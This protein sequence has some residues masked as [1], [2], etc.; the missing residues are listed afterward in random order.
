M[1]PTLA[2]KLKKQQEKTRTGESA[3]ENVSLGKK[4]ETGL[5]PV[6]ARRMKEQQE[7]TETGESAVEHCGRRSTI[8]RKMDPI[9]ERRMKQQQEKLE[10][11][12]ASAVEHVG[13]AADTTTKVD[14]KLQIRFSQQQEKEATGESSSALDEVA[15]PMR[16]WKASAAASPCELAGSELAERL[17]RQRASEE[18]ADAVPNAS[19]EDAV[20]PAMTQS[21][22]AA[23]AFPDVVSN[24]QPA[25]RRHACCRRRART[26][27]TE[28]DDFGVST[29][30][31]GLSDL[32]LAALGTAALVD[33]CRRLPT[34]VA[35]FR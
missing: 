28:D 17:S 3:V 16:K 31:V 12:D 9:L 29:H 1:D 26:T 7:K 33:A 34:L 5:D 32:A 20:E 8:E 23:E 14:P 2:E 19:D 10:T 35:F 21:L 30:V 27:T 24:P 18:A 15:S 6:L 25:A 11:G 22:T 4:V 13:S